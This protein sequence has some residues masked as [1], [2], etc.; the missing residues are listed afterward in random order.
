MTENLNLSEKRLKK[1]ALKYDLENYSGLSILGDS[2][3]YTLNTVPI[4]HDI[5]F[6]LLTNR[7]S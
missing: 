5:N 2:G 7:I 3:E 4:K 1:L 6:A